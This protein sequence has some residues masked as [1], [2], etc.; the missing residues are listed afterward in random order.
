MRGKLLGGRYRITRRI[1]EG[2]MAYVYLAKDEKLGR[3]VAIKILHKHMAENADIR[4]RFFQ[5]A[6]AISALDHPNILKLYDFSG[7][8]SEEL[9]MVMEVLQGLNLNEYVHTFPGN[10]LHPIIATMITREILKALQVAHQEGLIHRDIKPENI[11]ILNGGAVKLMDFGIVK[12]MRSNSITMT[13]T[14]MGSP[15][16]MSPEQIRGKSVD[17][18][19]DIYSLGVLFYEIITGKL[20]FNGNTTH[21]VV[22]K[23]CE[24]KFKEPRE[25]VP[26]LPEDLNKII[27]K[28]MSKH[29]MHRYQEARTFARDLDIFLR[30]HSFEESHIELERYFADKHKFEERLRNLNFTNKGTMQGLDLKSPKLVP[31]PKTTRT[32]IMSAD[33]QLKASVQQKNIYGIENPTPKV[34]IP[35]PPAPPLL[36]K[37]PRR[38]HQVPERYAPPKVSRKIKFTQN[39]V[40]LNP[41]YLDHASYT[42]PV[43]QRINR[44][45]FQQ[46]PGQLHKR[47]VRPRSPKRQPAPVLYYRKS[48]HAPQV[49]L[50]TPIIGAFFVGLIGLLSIM[51]FSNLVG[52]MPDTRASIENLRPKYNPMERIEAPSKEAPVSIQTSNPEVD[53]GAPS[54][55]QSVQKPIQRNDRG[56]RNQPI[57]L[58]Q[59]SVSL[60]TTSTTP[61]PVVPTTV[62]T[63]PPSS[64]TTKTASIN[65]NDS[66]ETLAPSATTEIAKVRISSRP[67]AEIYIDGKRVGTTVDRT[68]NSGWIDIS[69]GMRRIELRRT[70]YRSYSTRIHF[71]E[72][73]KRALPSITLEPDVNF[74]LTLSSNQKPVRVTLIGLSDRSRKAFALRGSPRDV[75]LPAGR[76]RA[77]FEYKGQVIERNIILGDSQSSINLNVDF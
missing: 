47:R 36:S 28:A 46:R 32:R 39:R 16:Y 45:Q 57:G 35:A 23:I 30:N 14:F 19:S 68:L 25:Y 77:R 61:S 54:N 49:P 34:N 40:A 76:Y 11:F 26:N 24:G 71:D 4:Q 33:E 3:H 67:A 48:V 41:T 75:V 43:Q 6:H 2:G 52:Q 5:E 53:K 13:G 31:P 12:N 66:S 9:W 38:D 56:K 64:A 44:A 60:P 15:S 65:G 37:A 27:C 69:P 55:P 63:T 1:G 29:P 10:W 72:G 22:L 42:A 8:S 21:D 50:L 18:R 51:G 74:T 73:E 58:P 17:H 7:K 59:R 70:G 62:E 20:P